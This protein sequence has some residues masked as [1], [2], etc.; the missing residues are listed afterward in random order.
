MRSLRT[1]LVVLIGLPLVLVVTLA[2]FLPFVSWHLTNDHDRRAWVA[3]WISVFTDGDV[4]LTGPVVARVF[5]RPEFILSGARLEV[6]RHG[7]HT[8]VAVDGARLAASLDGLDLGWTLVLHQPDIR[9]GTGR[10]DDVPGEMATA[11]KVFEGL[12]IQ[13]SLCA[14]MPGRLELDGGRVSAGGFG[15]D[16]D[17]VVVD[18]ASGENVLEVRGV[19]RRSRR[20]LLARGRRASVDSDAVSGVVEF[21]LMGAEV[22]VGFTMRDLLGPGGARGCWPGRLEA[23][24]KVTAD[25]PG[26]VWAATVRAVT[27][28]GTSAPSETPRA[29]PAQPDHKAPRLTGGATLD[30]ALRDGGD[31]PPV[32]IRDLRMRVD[33]VDLLSLNESRV[34]VGT[35]G[36]APPPGPTGDGEYLAAILREVEGRLRQ[37]VSSVQ[38]V[39]TWEAPVS[40]VADRLDAA[41]RAIEL[42][43]PAELRIDRATL[44]GAQFTD[45]TLRVGPPAL[46]RPGICVGGA[47]LQLEI[48]RAR[49]GAWEAPL[50]MAATVDYDRATHRLDSEFC[51]LGFGSGRQEAAI[52]GKLAFHRSGRRSGIPGQRVALE[53]DGVLPRIDRVAARLRQPNEGALDASAFSHVFKL[54]ASAISRLDNAGR[55]DEVLVVMRELRIDNFA[56]RA[57]LRAPKGGVA[58]LTVEP[59]RGERVVDATDLLSWLD[60]HPTSVQAPEQRVPR[61]PLSGRCARPRAPP[62][63]VILSG[64]VELPRMKFGAGV[65]EHVSLDL[66]LG[67]NGLALDD[68]RLES[69]GGV[70]MAGDVRA[71]TR[72]GALATSLD[73]CLDIGMRAP[74]RVV[75]WAVGAELLSQDAPLA[76]LLTLSRATDLSG[77]LILTRHSSGDVEAQLIGIEASIAGQRGAARLSGTMQRDHATGRVRLV[78]GRID[79]PTVDAALAWR[80]YAILDGRSAAVAPREL[81]GRRVSIAGGTLDVEFTQGAPRSVLLRAASL[82]LHPVDL[83]DVQFTTLPGGTFEAKARLGKADAAQFS[84][85]YDALVAAFGAP[86]AKGAGAMHGVID[87]V[88]E[89]LSVP[90]SYLGAVSARPEDRV[91]VAQYSLRAELRDGG[92]TVDRLQGAFDFRRIGRDTPCAIDADDRRELRT[93]F[94]TDDARGGRFVVRAKILPDAGRRWNV[95]LDVALTCVAPL[96]LRYMLTG[97]RDIAPDLPAMEGRVGFLRMKLAGPLDDG[98]F[99]LRELKGEGRFEALIALKGGVASYAGI[100]ALDELDDR[101][102]TFRGRLGLDGGRLRSADGPLV[103]VGGGATLSVNM[104]VDLV[105][106]C[107]TAAANV[108]SHREVDSR[109]GFDQYFQVE[110]LR[111]IRW[112]KYERRELR[113]FKPFK[114]S[115]TCPG[116]PGW[117]PLPELVKR[118][119]GG[120]RT[121]RQ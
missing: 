12:R 50:V 90:V 36:A 28:P 35:I 34:D 75:E 96:D 61:M 19:E 85:I 114:A 46:A 44:L 117:P 119:R 57:R 86:A 7:V 27:P 26:E 8:V 31:R 30:I 106:D 23:K 66:H 32:R 63:D 14:W 71:F 84:G 39:H 95:S 42:T 62:E 4:D 103:A 74:L 78:D 10:S 113:S 99:V 116:P 2:A 83:R 80:L 107:I 104:I 77:T 17:R 3:A 82:G 72:P 1:L 20:P 110:W 22:E 47:P 51:A 108:R 121:I 18:L 64:S 40:G 101:G 109:P 111:E 97:L 55:D 49:I 60:I 105:S 81:A 89:N 69:P 43:S 6:D 93:A 48:G 58:S 54:S 11:R 87:V 73:G 102:L 120:W 56:L 92:V 98:G 16:L 65:L 100:F 53:I 29:R 59:V 33:S 5:P 52:V 15:I 9:I 115:D 24:V 70:R 41:R 13:P 67:A 76:R 112:E 68:I 88:G 25:D 21:N 38:R 94:R 91:E 79:L 45:A 37:L 118:P